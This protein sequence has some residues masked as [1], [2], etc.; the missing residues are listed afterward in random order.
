VLGSTPVLLACGAFTLQVMVQGAWGIVP[1]HLNE[2]SP[3]NARGTLP[4]L[5]YQLGNLIAAATA[6]LQAYLAGLPGSSYPI[7]LGGMTAVVAVT[8]AGLALFGPEAKGARFEA[9]AEKGA[10]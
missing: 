10:A 8:L 6:T 4:G 7:A 3:G 1:A 2:L 5:A 9:A